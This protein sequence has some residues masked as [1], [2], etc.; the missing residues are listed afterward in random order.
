MVVWNLNFCVVFELELN[1][2]LFQKIKLHFFELCE[3]PFIQYYCISWKTNFVKKFF[4]VSLCKNVILL[5]QYHIISN[6][7]ILTHYFQYR[8]KEL[9]SLLNGL[10]NLRVR[11]PGSIVVILLK[12]DVRIWLRNSIS[13]EATSALGA[14]EAVPP[15]SKSTLSVETM[16][17][18]II[19][20]QQ[21]TSS[22]GRK[23]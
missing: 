12:T 16:L 18:L 15:E 17:L 1:P 8:K 4:F 20:S 19:F 6:I 10:V 9:S 11:I 2:Y 23:R 22:I 13:K 3:T 21:I 5:S 14:V 7:N